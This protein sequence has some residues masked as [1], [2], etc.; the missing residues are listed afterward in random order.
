MIDDRFELLKEE[1][2]CWGHDYIEDFLG[3]DIDSDEDK[4]VTEKRMD[5][6][7]MQMPVEELEK[8]YEK[9]KIL[10]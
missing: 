3:Y 2:F 8:F 9:F 7:Y 5:E 4:D 1:L 6:A 10:E